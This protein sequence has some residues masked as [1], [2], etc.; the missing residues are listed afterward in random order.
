MPSRVGVILRASVVSFSLA[1]GLVIA[2]QQAGT[3]GAEATADPVGGTGSYLLTATNTGPNY[4]S[5]FT[6]NGE[7]GIRVPPDGQGYEGGA[8]STQSELAG[9][10]AQSPSG[11]QLRANIPTWSTLTFS[12]AGQA[13]TLT[14]GNTSNWRQSINLRTGVIATAAR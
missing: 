2:V 11:V 9:F 1:G 14:R 3:S 13:F 6:G 8:V 10:Y 4:A 7:L 12:D 5:T